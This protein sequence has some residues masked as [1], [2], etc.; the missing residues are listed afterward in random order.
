M[1]YGALV[2]A[3]RPTRAS[4]NACLRGLSLAYAQSQTQRTRRFDYRQLGSWGWS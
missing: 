2:A 4:C 1:A 3:F